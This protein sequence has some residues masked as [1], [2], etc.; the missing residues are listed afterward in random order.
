MSDSRVMGVCVEE[1]NVSIFSL[2]T[3]WAYVLKKD[4]LGGKHMRKKSEFNQLSIFGK[5]VEKPDFFDGLM[6]FPLFQEGT[7]LSLHVLCEADHDIKLGYTL[8][9]RGKLMFDPEDEELVLHASDVFIV[10][11]TPKFKEELIKN[12]SIMERPAHINPQREVQTQT[13]PE[14]SIVIQPTFEEPII[15]PQPVSTNLVIEEQ[16]PPQQPV[17]ET[18]VA[19]TNEQTGFKL[20]K[21][22]T[23]NKVVQ[24]SQSITPNVS[25]ENVIPKETVPEF[26]P[27]QNVPTLEVNEHEGPALIS[28]TNQNEEEEGYTIQDFHC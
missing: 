10:E 7:N 12:P 23:E 9:A 8:D 22:S 25:V 14:D 13:L 18:P 20:F 5:V 17:V 28:N 1:F 4:V 19:Q 15:A 16:M 3:I 11:G 26:V 2:K 6:S 27:T 21:V 24:P